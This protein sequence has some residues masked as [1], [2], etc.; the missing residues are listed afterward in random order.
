MGRSSAGK[1]PQSKTTEPRYLGTLKIL[2]SK[3]LPNET[4]NLEA[5]DTIRASIYQVID[6]TKVGI[7]NVLFNLV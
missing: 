4:S 7:K 1:S 2:D 5:P 6:M 3:A